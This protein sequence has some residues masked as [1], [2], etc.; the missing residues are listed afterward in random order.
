MRAL[1]SLTSILTVAAGAA[2]LGSDWPSWRGPSNNGVSTDTGLPVTWSASCADAPAPPAAPAEPPAATPPAAPGQRGRGG[3]GGRRPATHPLQ[4]QQAR[5]PERRVEDPSARLQ[6]FDADH[7]RRHDLP[8]RR[9]RRQHRRARIVG[10]R[11]AQADG[12]VEAAARRHQPHGAQAEHV[13]AL[14]GDRRQA[15]LGHDR[16]RGAQGIRLLRAR[17]CGR[18]RSRRTTASSASTAAMPPRRC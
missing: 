9:H 12:R 4:L 8:E 3:R 2:L 10:D 13:V 1:L 5:D 7:L 16:G 18:A 11:S 17:S 6:R 14:A 15:C